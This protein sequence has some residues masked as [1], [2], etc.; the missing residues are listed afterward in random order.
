MDVRRICCWR[1]V[2]WPVLLSLLSFGSGC[3]DKSAPP[4]TAV[5]AGIQATEVS[6]A[7]EAEGPAPR[8][9]SEV[10][11]VHLIGGEKIGYSHTSTKKFGEGDDERI[12]TTNVTE[13]KL[14]RF[15]Q[16]VAQTITI[17]STDKPDGTPVSFRASMRSGAQVMTESTGR[18][19]DGQL[20]VK[21]VTQGQTVALNIPWKAEYGGPFASNTSLQ[22]QPLKPGETRT[23]LEF[24]PTLNMMGKVELTAKDYETTKLL[25]GEAKL[26][27]VETVATMTTPAGEQQMAST[28]WLDDKGEPLKAYL[29]QLKQFSYRTT[30]ERA[31]NTSG[32]GSFDLA[33]ATTVKLAKPLRDPHHAQA[34]TYKATLTDGKIDGVFVPGPSQA[35]KA[36]DKQ[37]CEV[38]VTAVRPDQPKELDKPDTE[39]TKQDRAPNALIQSDDK[40]VIEMAN[41][42]LA[43]EKDP[44]LLATALEQHVHDTVTNKNF[45]QTFA[46]AAEVAKHREGDCTE[47]AVLLAALCRARG[48]PARCAMGLVYY[49]QG[50]G[51]P[52]HMWTEVWIH[53][54]WV[55]LDATLGIGGI[56]GGHLK[57]A[58]SN[59]DGADAYSAFLPVLRVLGQLELEVVDVKR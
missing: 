57:L 38:T 7:A 15:G 45:S 17:T 53:D 11:D 10:W 39:P 52:Y 46:T 51:F 55:P 23:V 24:M 5:E 56:G 42:V 20:R 29:P 16:A 40:L 47:H 25:E 41:D 37:T 32:G 31:T 18:L 58:Q 21:A 49:D 12:E 44:W 54:R 33:T 2:A 30:K 9:T 43:G 48:I 50:Q 4:A 3:N 22:R 36:I 13:L 8:E 59:L 14:K 35:I 19:E 27:R 28:Q 34:I 6:A 26:L 1:F